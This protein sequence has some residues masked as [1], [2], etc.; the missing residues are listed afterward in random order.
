MIYIAI[1][2]CICLTGLRKLPKIDLH[3]LTDLLLQL[4]QL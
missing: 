1:F 2:R 3:F 4:L